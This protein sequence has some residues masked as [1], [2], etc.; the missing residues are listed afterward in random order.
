MEYQTGDTEE[1]GVCRVAGVSVPLWP[2]G[3]LWLAGLGAGVSSW[4]EVLRA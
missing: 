2:A 1:A 4:R 3:A